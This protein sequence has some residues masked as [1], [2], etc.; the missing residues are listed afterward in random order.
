M[1]I[2]GIS[3]PQILILLGI[4][5]LIFGTRKL[6]NVGSDLGHS[7]KQLRRGISDDD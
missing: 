2:A 3:T 6:R 7:L 4:V 5:V 1:G